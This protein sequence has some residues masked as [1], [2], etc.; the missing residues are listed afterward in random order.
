MR[1]SDRLLSRLLS[2]LLGSAWALVFIGGSKGLLLWVGNGNIFVAVLNMIIW[3]LPGLL[4]VVLVEY[5]FAGFEQTEEIKR[6][7][8]LLEKIEKNIENLQQNS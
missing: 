2:F 6:Q 8:K 5:L 4:M 1:L 7:S 3:T